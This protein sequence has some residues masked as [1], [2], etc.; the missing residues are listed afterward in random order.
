MPERYCV[1][2]SLPW[3]F[4]L[5]GSWMV[6]KISRISRYEMRCGSKLTFT[7]SAWPVLPLHTCS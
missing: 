4:R 1:P 7:T 5:V 3:R 2:T 6:K